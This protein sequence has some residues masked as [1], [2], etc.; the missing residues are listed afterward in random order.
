MSVNEISIPS[1]TRKQE[2]FNALSHFLGVLIA[3]VVFI[4]AI[5]KFVNNTLPIYYF[6]GLIIF[7]LSMATVYMISGIYH[8]LDKDNHYKKIFRILDHCS[9]YLLVA[10]TYTPICFVLSFTHSIGL[11]LLTIEWIGAISGIIMKAFFFNNKVTRTIAFLLYVILGWLAVFS[12]AFLYIDKTAFAFILG[13][14]ITYTI[15]AVLYALGKKNMNFHC[16]FHVFVLVSTVIQTIG[17]IL[18]I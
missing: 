7:A 9:I 4:F 14:G 18:M 11:I 6:L 5:N 8:Y 13:G 17:V 1:Y 2:T 12:G 3:I 16:V 15:G 10:G